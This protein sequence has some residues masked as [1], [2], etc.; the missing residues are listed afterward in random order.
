MKKI[1]AILAVCII[2]VCIISAKNKEPQM[3][4]H[5]V[6]FKFKDNTTP[7][8]VKQVEDA[9]RA[10]PSKIKEIKGFEWGINNSPE[11]LNQGLS[12]CF[13]LSFTS[14]KDRDIYLPHP[15]HKA[16]GAVLTPY[17]DKAVVLDYWAKD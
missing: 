1:I 11:N 10:L 3:L 8:Q 5:V 14:E 16:F 7:A 17:L 2:A 4:R 12:H 9:F 15:A 6:M 13:F